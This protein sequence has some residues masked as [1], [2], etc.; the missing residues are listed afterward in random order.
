MRFWNSVLDDV[1]PDPPGSIVRRKELQA[2]PL[3][4]RQ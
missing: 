1:A 2:R 4:R 3:P